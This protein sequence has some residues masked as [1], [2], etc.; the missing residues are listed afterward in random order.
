MDINRLKV[1]HLSITMYD[2][3][4]GLMLECLCKRRS[5]NSGY[6]QQA[7]IGSSSQSGF[8][9]H[10]LDVKQCMYSL[11]SECAH[12]RDCENRSAFGFHAK[13]DPNVT[14]DSINMTAPDSKRQCDLDLPRPTY[15][16]VPKLAPRYQTSCLS[17]HQ[18]AAMI[19]TS[20]TT[21][22]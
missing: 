14:S 20:T 19:F 2:R 8:R 10:R 6:H 17:P 1:I 7:S 4:D 16:I 11:S 9:Q 15:C 3:N 5:R 18:P 13:F 12:L 22:Y 21:R